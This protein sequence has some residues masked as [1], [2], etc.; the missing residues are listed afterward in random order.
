MS[1]LTLYWDLTYKCNLN[2]IHCSASE[3]RNRRFIQ[4]LLEM[5]GSPKN[6]REL[7]YRDIVEFLGIL[8]SDS[9]V[10]EVFI[11]PQRGESTIHQDFL[12]IWNELSTID[13]IKKL[14]LMTNGV[15]LYK[16]LKAMNLEKT[17]NVNI[18][19]DGGD[20]IHD[21]IRG[22]GTFRR[23]LKSLVA[24]DE[25]KRDEPDFY[26][27]VN[28]VLNKINADSLS[29]LFYLLKDLSIKNILVNVIPVILI[30]GNAKVNRRLLSIPFDE[31]I[32]NISKAYLDFKEINKRRK[33][34]GLYPLKLRFDFSPKQ[35]FILLNRMKNFSASTLMFPH[36]TQCKAKSKQMIYITPYGN[37]LP[38]GH[39]AEP[40]VL[41]VFYKDMG[42]EFPP[43]VFHIESIDEIIQSKF[44]VNARDWI[45][46][47]KKLVLSRHPCASCPFRGSCNVCEI[48]SYI[49]GVPDEKI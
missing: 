14:S 4:S 12:K 48:Y 46:Q 33:A 38:C 3:Y 42:R 25:I 44:F 39:F 16:Y 2:C 19:I 40:E 1:T 24:V 41:N 6:S 8:N 10:F 37:L 27:Q 9:R 23:V 49:W 34:N 35:Y 20:E 32:D 5:L 28:F 43:H 18:S 26:L 11:S 22:K 7:R 45:E 29:K 17:K 13:N 31:I 21:K 36:K 30:R 47:V 15:I